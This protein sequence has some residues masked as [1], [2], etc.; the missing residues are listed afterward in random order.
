MPK[1]KSKKKKKIPR[2][3]DM[4]ELMPSLGSIEEPE[5]YEDQLMEYIDSEFMFSGPLEFYGAVFE[6]KRILKEYDVGLKSKKGQK[7]LQTFVEHAK[8]EYY[9]DFDRFLD[10][11]NCGEIFKIDLTLDFVNKI[12]ARKAFCE[13]CAK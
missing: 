3:P 11:D 2:D 4:E 5:S 9:G 12:L 7:I 8:E 1:R 10:C 6:V 13:N